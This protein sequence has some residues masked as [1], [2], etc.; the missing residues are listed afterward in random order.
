MLFFL[1]MDHQIIKVSFNIQQT[2]NKLLLFLMTL[3]QILDGLF[4]ISFYDFMFFFCTSCV[5]ISSMLQAAADPAG[6]KESFSNL[7]KSKNMMVNAKNSRKSRPAA[8][9]NEACFAAC[10][11]LLVGVSC[12]QLVTIYI[13][14][15][16]FCSCFPTQLSTRFDRIHTISV[17]I[18]FK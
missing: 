6:L 8:V 11:V 2:S 17:Q 3:Y 10:F 1:T 9:Q 7:A 18:T 16:I 5:R 15:R 13:I 14:Y 12:W 4:F